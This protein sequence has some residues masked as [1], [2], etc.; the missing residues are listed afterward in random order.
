MIFK[1]QFNFKSRNNFELIRRLCFREENFATLVN[2]TQQTEDIVQGLPKIE[3]LV[4]A[5]RP[6]VK[7]RFLVDL[8]LF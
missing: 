2:Y 6:K 4:E 1:M 7:F 3:E 8:G 5:R